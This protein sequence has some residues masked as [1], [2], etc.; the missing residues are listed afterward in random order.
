MSEEGGDDE[1]AKTPLNNGT[2]HRSNRTETRNKL[3]LTARHQPNITANGGLD[4]ETD[5][6]AA[7]RPLTGHT[8]NSGITNGHCL[9]VTN[10]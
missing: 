8:E 4:I 6:E 7:K 3:E 10:L 5:V 9:P 2:T 1:A